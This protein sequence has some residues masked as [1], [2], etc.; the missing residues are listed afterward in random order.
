MMS[1]PQAK[2][3]S[4]SLTSLGF[5]CQIKHLSDPSVWDVG[6][7][8]L[9]IDFFGPNNTYFLCMII[10][11]FEITFFLSSASTWTEYIWAQ[12]ENWAWLGSWGQRG[13]LDRD[14]AGTRSGWCLQPWEEGASSQPCKWDN[15]THLLAYVEVGTYKHSFS[16]R[17]RYW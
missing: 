14:G 2:R 12:A 7:G 10:G 16:I 5:W 3:P 9:E 17:S 6:T 13:M 11:W 15:W 8:R 1:W 4:K